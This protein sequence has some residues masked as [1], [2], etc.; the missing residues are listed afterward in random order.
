MTTRRPGARCESDRFGES[1]LR[2][3]R[4]LFTAM[5]VYEDGPTMPQAFHASLCVDAIE[6]THRLVLRYGEARI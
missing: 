2:G 4:R 3:Q 6:A 1:L 5:V